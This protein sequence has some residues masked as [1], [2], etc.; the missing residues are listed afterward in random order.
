MCFKKVIYNK[1]HTISAFDGSVIFSETLKCLGIN[2]VDE[3]RDKELK[4]DEVIKKALEAQLKV[5]IWFY[6][7]SY[8]P[9]ALST[10][11][12]YHQTLVCSPDV[13]M[14]PTCDQEIDV[15]T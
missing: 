8:Q 5:P 2:F 11:K 10:S 1:W 6:E 3:G 15:Q 7:P 9:S 13:R 12:Q 14:L 4:V